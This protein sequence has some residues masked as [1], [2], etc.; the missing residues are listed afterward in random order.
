MK[1]PIFQGT[2]LFPFAHRASISGIGMLKLQHIHK[3]DYFSPHL[4]GDVGDNDPECSSTASVMELRIQGRFLLFSYISY[5]FIS[6]PGNSK[7]RLRTARICSI[8][9]QTPVDAPGCVNA[10]GQLKQKQ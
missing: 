1:M 10:A 4:C 3:S 2:P 6:R 7:W 8:K 5:F 9:L